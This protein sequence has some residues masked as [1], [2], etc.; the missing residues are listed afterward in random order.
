[1]PSF[2]VAKVVILLQLTAKIQAAYTN[3]TKAGAGN[4]VLLYSGWNCTPTTM[5]ELKFHNFNQVGFG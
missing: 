5:D 4:T 2:L 1:M 3:S